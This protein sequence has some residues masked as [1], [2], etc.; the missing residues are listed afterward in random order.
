MKTLFA[1]C[2]LVAASIGLAGCGE[3]GPV[4]IALSVSQAGSGENRL[5]ADSSKVAPDLAGIAVEY[6]VVGELSPMPSVGRAWS[7][8]PYGEPLRET[9]R[10]ADAFGM[11]VKAK[12]STDDKNLFA[13]TDESSNETVTLWNHQ[14]I[15]G[16]WSYTTASADV[17]VSSPGCAP[18]D[19]SCV[20]VTEPTLPT[21]LLSTEEALARATEFLDESQLKTSDY[22]L[23]AESTQWG[24]YVTGILIAGEVTSNITVNFSYGANGTL[25][26]AAG[27][28]VSVRMGDE[29]PLV[30]AAQGVARLS[31]PRYAMFGTAMVNAVDSASSDVSATPDNAVPMTIP[32]T[33]VRMTLMESNLSNGTHMLLPAFTYS[34]ADGDVGSVV[35][36]SDEYLVFPDDPVPGDQGPTEPAPDIDP[37]ELTTQSAESLIG[38]TE[39]EAGKVAAERGWTVRTAMR[40]GEAFMLTSDYRTDRVNLTVADDVVVSVE[41]G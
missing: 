5:A 16:W 34:N 39:S 31:Q 11:S 12:R 1:S 14:A 36:L 26:Y 15:G 18:D 3:S 41:I 21:N 40:D 20:T 8:G 28:M 37:V 9:Q 2:A 22:V 29:Y 27:P 33:G 10:I 17:A 25:E 13:A 24:T 7:V 6:Q 23:T 30:D 4:V 19:R 35:A 38:L 32:I